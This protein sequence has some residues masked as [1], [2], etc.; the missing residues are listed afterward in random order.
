MKSLEDCKEF[1]IKAYTTYKEYR[2]I[3]S[4]EQL[5]AIRE[6]LYFIYGK[7]INPILNRWAQDARMAFYG[8]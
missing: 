5:D 3:L 2:D 7:E 1:Y 8:E 4:R 6:T